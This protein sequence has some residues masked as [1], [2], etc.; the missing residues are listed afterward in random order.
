[1]FDGFER[2][3][4][5]LDQVSIHYRRS[6]SGADAGDVRADLEGVRA[7]LL[8]LVFPIQP[9]SLPEARIGAN[10]EFYLLRRLDGRHA[11]LARHVRRLS[12]LGHHRPRT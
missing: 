8:P 4:A 6:W 3:S 1:M 11:G 7:R 5:V 12:G 9:A 10:P 2:A